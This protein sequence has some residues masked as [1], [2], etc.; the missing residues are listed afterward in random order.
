MDH[1]D[2]DLNPMRVVVG[3]HPGVGQPLAHQRLASSLHSAL[4]LGQIQRVIRHDQRHS[5]YELHG[6]LRT[7]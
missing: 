7:A 6:D 5:Y 2:L 3:H 1:P 4:Q